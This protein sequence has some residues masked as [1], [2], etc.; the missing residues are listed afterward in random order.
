MNV[1]LSI[2]VS[3]NLDYNSVGVRLSIGSHFLLTNKMPEFIGLSEITSL[4]CDKN[5][6]TFIFQVFGMASRTC[7]HHPSIIFRGVHTFLLK[8][9]EM[10]KFTSLCKDIR[11]G[12]VSLII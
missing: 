8:H 2:I 6:L 1:G 9:V 7:I 11:N 3:S 10:Q 5:I 4:P 12:A